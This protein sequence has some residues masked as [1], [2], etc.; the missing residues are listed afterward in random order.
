MAHKFAEI[1]FTPV[2]RAIQVEEG[3]RRM[4]A[5]MDEGDDYNHQLGA[6]EASFIAARDSLYMA[7]VSETGWPY[8]QHRGGPAGFMK[9]LDQRT[10][11]FADYAGNRQY[12]STGNFRTDNRVALFFMDYPNRKR[13]KLLGRVRTIGPD[14]PELLT[15]LEDDD[16]PARVERGFIIG[17][18]GFDWN[19]P[20]HITP[21]YTEA[22]VDERL[23]ELRTENRQLKDLL[24]A[25]ANAP[26][27]NT[28]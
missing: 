17:V 12:V 26:T 14:E 15:R 24:A 10:I 11:G 8:I 18:E 9:V 20:Q 6:R 3:S 19:C 13:L 7:S 27:M 1:A 22:Q 2:V 16:Y 25:Y 4:Y 21:R 23:A 5:R 28:V